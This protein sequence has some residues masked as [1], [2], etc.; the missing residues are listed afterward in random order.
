MDLR[1]HNFGKIE[2]CATFVP[3]C[4]NVSDLFYCGALNYIKYTSKFKSMYCVKMN[5]CEIKY[6]STGQKIQITYLQEVFCSL[7]LVLNNLRTGISFFY[8]IYLQHKMCLEYY[9]SLHPLC[10]RGYQLV[11]TKKHEYYFY[12]KESPT[13]RK[14]FLKYHFCKEILLLFLPSF[15]QHS[16]LIPLLNQ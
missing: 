4:I 5:G 1:C 3:P 15:L 6:N 12:D 16:F 10:I 7:G 14:S 13:T 11:N 8:H 9:C 2:G